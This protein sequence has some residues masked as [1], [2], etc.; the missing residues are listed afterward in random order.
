VSYLGNICVS[1]TTDT[2]FDSATAIVIFDEWRGLANLE[3]FNKD[4]AIAYDRIICLRDGMYTIHAQ[5]LG[6]ASQQN[7]KIY[8]NTTMKTH[9]NLNADGDDNGVSNTITQPLKRGDYIQLKGRW[10]QAKD[11]SHFE[12][13]RA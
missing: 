4:F 5:T 11:Y 12:I 1:T 3:H 7:V 6:N 9:V 2:S 10:Y 8:I 13:R